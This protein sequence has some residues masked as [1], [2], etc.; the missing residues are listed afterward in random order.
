MSHHSTFFRAFL[1][2]VSHVGAVAPSSNAL[3][4]AMVDGID[5]DDVS[6]AVE[7]GTGTGVFTAEILSSLKPGSRLLAVERDSELAAIT[8]TRCP[9]VPVHVECAG[10]IPRLCREEGIEEVGAVISGLPWAS[11]SREMQETCLSAVLEVL[12]PGGYFATFAYWQGLAL[13]AGR[14]FRRI[15]R[16]RFSEVEQS[17]T[18]WRNLP[19]AFAYRC[20]V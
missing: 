12:R 13:P 6:V 17:P 9:G 5:W 8:R 18:I 10:Q 2:N 16:E 20:R 19:P 4:A 3:A 7:L 1:R 14:R 11:F 15:L